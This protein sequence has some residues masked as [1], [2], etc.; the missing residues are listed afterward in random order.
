VFS[1][2]LFPDDQSVNPR[3]TAYSCHPDSIETGKRNYFET[4]NYIKDGQ[5]HTYTLIVSVPKNTTLH[6][7]GWL[8]DFDN[9]PDEWEKHVSIENISITYTSA[10]V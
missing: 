4:I 3:I 1:V 10:F 8:Y 9:H 2:T 5:P 6:F 7:K